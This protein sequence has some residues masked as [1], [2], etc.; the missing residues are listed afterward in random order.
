MFTINSHTCYNKSFFYDHGIR[1]LR[2]RSDQHLMTVHQK[3]WHSLPGNPPKA[4]MGTCDHPMLIHQWLHAAWTWDFL[5][6]VQRS[7]K[8]I[9]TNPPATA[10]QTMHVS[11]KTLKCDTSACHQTTNTWLYNKSNVEN[12]SYITFPL[13]E[14]NY[15][16]LFN[17]FSC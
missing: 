7:L 1:M 9:T 17:F 11:G 3:S 4:S 5:Y 10:L 2:E 12:K 8:I 6:W 16:S 13:I 15:Y 14:K